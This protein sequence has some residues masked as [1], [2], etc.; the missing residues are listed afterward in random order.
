MDKEKDVQLKPCPL[1]GCS[2]GIAEISSSPCDMYTEWYAK[3]E[4]SCG[5]TFEREWMQAQGGILG[6]NIIT[7]WNKRSDET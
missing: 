2:V 5:L 7:L 4:C 1:C 3:I 6:E